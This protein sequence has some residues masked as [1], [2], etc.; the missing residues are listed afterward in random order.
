MKKL[1]LLC[2]LSILMTHFVQAQCVRDSSILGTQQILA[3]RPYSDS[4]PVVAT[5]PVCINEPYIQ[6][7]TLNVPS[8]FTFNG[9]TAPL[10]SVAITQT[11]AITNL[12]VGLNYSCDPPTCRF[13][14]ET[15]GCILLAGTATPNNTIG[16][17]DLGIKLKVFTPLFPIDL[18][19]PGTIAPGQHFYLD[20]RAQG[21]C[22]SSG[23]S[24]LNGRINGLKVAPNPF[25]DRTTISLVSD[26]NDMFRFEVFNV[27]G[28][29]VHSEAVQ[30][31][32]GDNQIVFEAGDLAN[33]T[34]Y[35]SL[36]GAQGR[37]TLS[38]VIQH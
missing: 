32:N 6:S 36:R 13:K 3:P 37:I 5:A 17:A 15:L 24:D 35:F 20:V 28:E 30:I 19:F 33:G 29:I 23:V 11:G 4:F 34:Y 8:Q 31:V 12:P 7:V 18:E 9:I 21:S 16:L 14:K 26:M 38:F 27:L 2:S 10:D 1:V 25:G 22:A